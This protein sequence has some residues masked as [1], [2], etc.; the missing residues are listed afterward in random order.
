MKARHFAASAAL[1]LGM[2]VP[3]AETFSQSPP[4]ERGPAAGGSPEWFLQG[5][6]A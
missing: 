4:L 1:A 2:I 3:A 6:C 5:L